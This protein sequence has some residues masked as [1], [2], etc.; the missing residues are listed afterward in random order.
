MERNNIFG[1]FLG[2]IVVLGFYILLIMLII[3]R[4]N[5]VD[6]INLIV[7]ALVGAFLTVVAYYFGSSK[8]S[9]DKNRMFGLIR[10][11]EPNQKLLDEI[12]SLKRE[13]LTL[14]NIQE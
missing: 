12:E 10:S 9:S 7:G 3:Y 2:A 5:M 8:G 4:P 1:Y 11:D 6:V 13:N 14:K